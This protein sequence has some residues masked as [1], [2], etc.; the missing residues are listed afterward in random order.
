[1]LPRLQLF[2]FNA[3]D[4]AGSLEYVASALKFIF[5]WVMLMPISTIIGGK[6]LAQV[7]KVQFRSTQLFKLSIPRMFTVQASDN[8]VIL[9]FT[10]F[11]ITLVAIALPVGPRAY[12]I[13]RSQFGIDPGQFN[14]LC[15][16]SAFADVTWTFALFLLL[17]LAGK[18]KSATP[19]PI[20]VERD[21]LIDKLA[22][23]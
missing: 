3:P 9:G 21:K 17:F 7:L 16:L 2:A 5:S 11:I 10:G 19:D 1:M 22:K 8:E 13:F 4:Q 15:V 14:S 23:Q 18:V 20:S 12:N 6:L